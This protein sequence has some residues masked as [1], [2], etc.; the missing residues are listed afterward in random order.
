M[1]AIRS[2][3]VTGV[4]MG[5]PGVGVAGLVGGRR[6][7]WVPGGAVQCTSGTGGG[8]RVG[9]LVQSAGW[10]S[11]RPLHSCC[12]RIVATGVV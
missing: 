7:R 2:D 11:V 10:C 5:P 1:A 8:A 12:R 3:L 9:G 4:V 6:G